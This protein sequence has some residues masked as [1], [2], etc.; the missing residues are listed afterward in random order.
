MVSYVQ[1]SE[2][3]PPKLHHSRPQGTPKD[4]PLNHQ[5]GTDPTA[6]HPRASRSMERDGCTKDPDDEE[7]WK[8]EWIGT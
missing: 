1:R 5:D 4:G 6:N 7:S 8:E 3:A 2:V